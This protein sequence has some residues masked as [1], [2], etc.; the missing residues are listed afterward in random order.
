MHQFH[1]HLRSTHSPETMPIT[2][3]SKKVRRDLNIQPCP[4]C[5]EIPGSKDFVRHVCR[6]CEEIALSSLS[7]CYGEDSEDSADS[8]DGEISEG[9]TDMFSRPSRPM[10]SQP[11][12]LD[13]PGPRE[14]V[15]CHACDNE[16][17]RDEHGLICPRC[18]SDA[19]EIVSS[20]ILVTGVEE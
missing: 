4:F 7:R 3:E 20:S 6:H 17:Y 1:R 2:G 18:D 12:H 9:G 16:W 10:I 11:R 14:V 8:E 13:A 19:T 5:A 15:Y